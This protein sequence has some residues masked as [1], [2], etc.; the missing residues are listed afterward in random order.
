TLS[1]ELGKVIGQQQQNINYRFVS[2]YP[3]KD[4]APHVLDDVEKKALAALRDDPHQQIT[5]ISRSAFSDRI[6]LIAP[7][8]MEKPCV[9]CHN[10][11]PYSSKQDWKVGDVRGIQ[12]LAI[13]Q[14]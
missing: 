11:H 8:I 3:F 10:A 13:T 12:E 5:D 14:P 6:R 1:L 4:R 2:D 7:V 9:D